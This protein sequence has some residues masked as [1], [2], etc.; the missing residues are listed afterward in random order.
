MCKKQKAGKGTRGGGSTCPKNR[1]LGVGVPAVSD[2]ERSN[3]GRVGG[4]GGER[5]FDQQTTA[6]TDL[7]RMTFRGGV[8]EKGKW[9]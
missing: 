8:T 2:W 5:R 6:A 3:V 1:G 4:G 7:K 9:V